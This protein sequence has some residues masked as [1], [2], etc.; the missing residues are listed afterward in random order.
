MKYL[1][2]KPFENI[3]QL[4][5][6]RLQTVLLLLTIGFTFISCGVS[7]SVQ[8]KV[9]HTADNVVPEWALPG[10]KTHKQI[11]P[12]ID[13]HRPTKTEMQPIG[14]F[15]G[16]SD[17]GAALVAG[18]SSYDPRLKQY[19]INS[20]GYNIWYN[21][22]EFRFLWKKMTGDVSLAADVSFP[23]TAGYLDR[24]AVVII[25]QSLDDDSEEAMV[26]LHGGGLMHMAWRS[27]KNNMIVQMMVPQRKA[28]RIGLEKKGDAY[29]IFVSMNG[30]PMH[31]L[32]YPIQ[33]RFKEPF[34]VGIGFCSHLPDKVDKAILSNVILENL[35]GKVR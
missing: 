4:N 32:G 1:K 19:T 26:A 27:Q 15:E 14:I 10:S 7:N 25:R 34:Y 18:S 9:K 17:V 30:E 23:D 29:A 3:P 12:P 2:N 13:F 22:D 8:E 24:K 11:P 28:M 31:Q 16:Q 35:A 21:R 5:K 20:A 33:L 6:D